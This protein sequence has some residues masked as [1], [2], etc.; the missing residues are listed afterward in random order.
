MRPRARD[1]EETRREETRLREALDKDFKIAEKLRPSSVS[2]NLFRFPYCCRNYLPTVQT[3]TQHSSSQEPA[4]TLYY[5]QTEI[6]TQNLGSKPLLITPKLPLWP[7]I[8]FPSL[9]WECLP[10]PRHISLSPFPTSMSSNI[11]KCG[12]GSP[13]DVAWWYQTRCGSI[14]SPSVWEEKDWKFHS[15]KFRKPDRQKTC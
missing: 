12:V 5:L 8:L 7:R 9:G 10:A 15:V 6:P 1:A 4:A 2:T 14:V 13:T 11:W 3:R